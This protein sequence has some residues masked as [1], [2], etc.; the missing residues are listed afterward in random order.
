MSFSVEKELMPIIQPPTGVLSFTPSA[1]GTVDTS[2]LPAT[3]D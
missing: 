3:A 2:Y 1:T